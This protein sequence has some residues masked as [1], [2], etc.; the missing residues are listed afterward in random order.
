MREHG[1]ATGNVAVGRE[2]ATYLR[3]EKGMRP[4]TCEAYARDIDTAEVQTVQ[5]PGQG[6]GITQAVVLCGFG[7]TAVTKAAVA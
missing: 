2:Y 5:S 7:W 1:Q 4:A 3:V 6:V